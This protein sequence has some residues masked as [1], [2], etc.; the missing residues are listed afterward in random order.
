MVIYL[1]TFEKG[2]AAFKNNIF[3]DTKN[4]PIYSGFHA[5]VPFDEQRVVFRP[6]PNGFVC[7]G[8]SFRQR[9]Q[10]D[11]WSERTKKSDFREL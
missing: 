3:L 8:R 1:L 9:G 7:G 5:Y 2:F 6:P 4:Q 10:V 11:F